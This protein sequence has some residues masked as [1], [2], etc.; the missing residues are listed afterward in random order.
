MN[1][2]LQEEGMILAGSPVMLG[3]GSFNPRRVSLVGSLLPVHSMKLVR[4][5]SRADG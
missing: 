3:R 5:L 1:Y 2:P 4:G